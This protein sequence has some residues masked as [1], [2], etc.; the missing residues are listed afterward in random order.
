MAGNA[1]VSIPCGVTSK[2]LPLGLQLIADVF[3]EGVMLR[4]AKAVEAAK[5]FPKLQAVA[6]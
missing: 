3:K 4:A 6:A 2:G 5:P 1:S